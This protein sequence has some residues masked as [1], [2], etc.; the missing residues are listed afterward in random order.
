MLA[1]SARTC[2]VLLTRRALEHLAPAVGTDPR[3][4]RV[5]PRRPHRANGGSDTK[6]LCAH[7]TS[8]SFERPGAETKNTGI[9][10]CVCVCRAASPKNRAAPFNQDHAAQRPLPGRNPG[11]QSQLPIGCNNTHR[12]PTKRRANDDR[13]PQEWAGASPVSQASIRNTQCRNVKDALHLRTVGSTEQLGLTLRTVIIEATPSLAKCPDRDAQVAT[14]P[15]RPN[16]ALARQS[17]FE[18]IEAKSQT[19]RV[20]KSHLAVHITRSKRS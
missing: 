20:M 18:G 4:A 9:G 16:W 10:A 14:P 17:M 7:I 12:L 2:G 19:L 11:T 13:A 15:A 8:N 6:R 1:H 5:T 3:V